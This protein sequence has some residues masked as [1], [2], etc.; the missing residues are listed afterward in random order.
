MEADRQ[1][2]LRR[3]TAAPKPTSLGRVIKTKLEARVRELQTEVQRLRR[4]LSGRDG[5]HLTR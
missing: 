5:I 4:K 2:S 1:N 3:E